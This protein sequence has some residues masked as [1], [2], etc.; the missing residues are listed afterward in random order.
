MCCSSYPLQ[1][2]KWFILVP[3]MA[4]NVRD[5]FLQFMNYKSPHRRQRR[6]QRQHTRASRKTF[7][8]RS[9]SG[10]KVAKWVG[11]LAPPPWRRSVNTLAENTHLLRKGKYHCTTDFLFD[12]F[13]FG[14]T[15][16]SVDSFIT[17][18]PQNP[19]KFNRR[20]VV[21]WKL[22]LLS[23]WVFSDFGQSAERW[24]I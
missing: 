20:S 13:G 12:W 5:N 11:L 9:S 16:K 4:K 3:Q 14:Q 19:N 10:G 6:H 23:N 22:P 8:S 2:Q 18:K 24:N 17:T 7:C 21:Q 1:Q 15:S